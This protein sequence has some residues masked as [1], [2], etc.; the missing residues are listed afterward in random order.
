VYVTVAAAE[1]T[2]VQPNAISARGIPR[3]PSPIHLG[4]ALVLVAFAPP[5]TARAQA[6]AEPT[7]PP[8]PPPVE[9][10]AATEAVEGPSDAAAPEGPSIQVPGTPYLPPGAPP[11]GASAH[12]GRGVSVTSADG[13]FSLTVRGRVQA[14]AT[15]LDDPY[16][17]QVDIAFAIRRARLVF[18]GHLWSRDVQFYIQLGLAPLDLEPDQNLVVRDAVISWLG[19][20]DLQLRVGQTKVPFNR[21][22][23]ISSSALQLVDRS[24]VNAE[25][26]LDRDI[27][28][29]LFSNDLFGLA[30]RLGYQL[31]LT[32]GDGRNRANRG[33]G[34]LYVARLQ[35]QPL[36]AFDP[37]DSY[38]E[39][40]ISR[41][42][43]PRL[44]LGAGFGY[45]QGSRRAF[46]THG[47]FFQA[48]TFDQYHAEADLIFKQKGFSVQAEL[49]Y[50]QARQGAQTTLIEGE[51][52]T[53]IARSGWGYMLQAGYVFPSMWEVAARWAELIPTERVESVL[54][55]RRELTVGASYYFSEHNLKVQ[56]DYGYL[57]GRDLPRGHHMARVQTQLFF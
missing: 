54:D 4:V 10:G 12:F 30:G 45:N 57:F 9:T 48:H 52:V 49:L 18:L 29:H 2:D 27:G 22:R 39:A 47:T 17:E 37:A 5:M 14:R 31:S 50:R 7:I 42:P 33:T 46:S 8:A 16:E 15:V 56:A 55:A 3:R 36:G 13:R 23:V 1:R 24:I 41:N 6:P 25:L 26:N 19:W 28:I 38:S 20:R 53:D 35:V 21:E 32:G 40:D 34:L 43:R 11:P 44:S 51:L